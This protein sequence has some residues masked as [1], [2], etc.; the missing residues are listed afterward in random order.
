[1]AGISTRML[2]LGGLENKYKYN[3]IEEQ[4][5]EFGDGNEDVRSI[6][7]RS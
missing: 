1:M 6:T 4:R 7:I 5:Q 3:G 2:N